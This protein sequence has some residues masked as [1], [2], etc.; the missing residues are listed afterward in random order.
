[1]EYSV[2]NKKQKDRMKAISN[3]TYV[4]EWEEPQFMDYLLGELPKVRRFQNDSE[5][6][7]EI[8]LLEKALTT[9]D[10]FLSE[11]ST[12]LDEIAKRISD[13][14]NLKD[15]WYGLSLYEIETYVKIHSFCLISGKGGIGKSYFIKCF[16][17]QLEQKNIAHLCIYGKFEKN[18]NNIDVEEII[19]ASDAGFVFIVDAINEMSEEGQHNLL[20]VLMELKKYP[21][22]RII[23]SYRTNSNDII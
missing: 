22:I 5:V 14:H 18:T 2:L 11:K 7:H 8:S 12:F 20:G 6:E 19:K 4:M 13:I 21:R 23:I 17:E 16:E 15:S 9:Y 1:M 3:Q 10:A